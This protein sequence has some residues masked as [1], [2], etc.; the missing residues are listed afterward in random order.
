VKRGQPLRRHL[1]LLLH[2]NLLHL[3]HIRLLLRHHL[4]LLL[5]LLHSLLV[6]Y[7]LPPV[8]PCECTIGLLPSHKARQFIPLGPRRLKIIPG[9]LLLE[10]QVLQLFPAIFWPRRPVTMVQEEGE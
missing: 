5:M 4:M 7:L 1:L 2:R 10:R 3:H 6:L 8:V 9:N